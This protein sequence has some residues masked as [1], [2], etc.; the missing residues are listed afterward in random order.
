MAETSETSAVVDEL[1]AAYESLR[2]KSKNED[3]SDQKEE[4][5]QLVNR[6]AD[7]LLKHAPRG[8]RI[9]LAAAR[10]LI[11]YGLFAHVCL[12]PLAELL[13]DLKSTPVNDGAAATKEASA[14]EVRLLLDLFEALAVWRSPG[15]WPDA[16][17][18]RRW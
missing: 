9:W 7:A 14:P 6:M 4:S 12:R 1:L 15:S 11:D 3:C 13:R 8:D 16:R 18:L 2:S 17:R 5:L 10:V